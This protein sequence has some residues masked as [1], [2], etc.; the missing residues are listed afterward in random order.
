MRDLPAREEVFV[1]LGASSTIEGDATRA[2]HSLR[3][4]QEPIHLSGAAAAALPR[5]HTL[6]TLERGPLMGAAAELPLA[7]GWGYRE[8]ER[9]WAARVTRKRVPPEGANV[10]VP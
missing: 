3:T 1:P 4:Y 7:A 6:C 8:L 2:P 9:C 10:V 5:T